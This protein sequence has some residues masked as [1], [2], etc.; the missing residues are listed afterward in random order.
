IVSSEKSPSRSVSLWQPAQYARNTGATS[1]SKSTA[2][3]AATASVRNRNAAAG[4][5]SVLEEKF[6]AGEQRPEQGLA[7]GAEIVG[8]TGSRQHRQNPAALGVGRRSAQAQLPRAVDDLGGRRA[9]VQQPGD[10]PF[11]RGEL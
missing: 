4:F 7:G 8:Q 3:R 9:V 10:D 2:A 11:L 1:R 6:A 5:M